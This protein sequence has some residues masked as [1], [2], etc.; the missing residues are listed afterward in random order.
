MKKNNLKVVKIEKAKSLFKSTQKVLDK[1]ANKKIL[2]K[3][4]ASRQKS[5]LTKSIK[6]LG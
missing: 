1:L 6:A 5:R 4:K 3:N 2:S